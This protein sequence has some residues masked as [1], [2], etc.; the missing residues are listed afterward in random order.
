[1]PLVRPTAILAALAVVALAGCGGGSVTIPAASGAH[2]A[3]AS[4]ARNPA[5]A[6]STLTQLFVPDATGA[7]VDVYDT[8]GNLQYAVPVPGDQPESLT[9]DAT[10]ALYVALTDRSAVALF[11]RPAN[12]KYVLLSDSGNYPVAAAVAPKSLLV[13]VANILSTSGGPGS[14]SFYERGKTK[15]CANVSDATNFARVYFEAFDANGNLFVDGASAAGRTTV[16]EIAGGCGAKKIQPLVLK[17][18]TLQFPGGVAVNVKNQIVV[19]DQQAGVL[20]TFAQP[21][22][23]SLGKPLATTPLRSGGTVGFA[24]TKNGTDL[25]AASGYPGISEYAY[26]AGGTPVKSLAVGYGGIAVTPAETP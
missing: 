15:A 5:R 2:A 16:G 23:G 10:G 17:G 24:L 19:G 3:G 26:P 25:W 8:S 13:A 1:M 21:K 11:A 22:G 12:G 4:V 9:T 20:Y 6:P 18:V 14:V 7:H